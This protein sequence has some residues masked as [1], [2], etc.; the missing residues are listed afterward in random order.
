MKRGGVEVNADRVRSWEF[1]FR[2][3]VFGEVFIKEMRH[4]FDVLVASRVKLDNFC[5]EGGQ[6]PKTWKQVEEMV[7]SPQFFETFIEGGKTGELV[8]YIFKWIYAATMETADWGW[9]EDALSAYFAREGMHVS[10]GPSSG[11][12][13][14]VHLIKRYAKKV[15]TNSALTAFKEKQI[16]SWGFSIELHKKLLE[17][18]SFP[19]ANYAWEAHDIS[20]MLDELTKRKMT[21]VGVCVF[22]TLHTLP[23]NPA[24]LVK[25]RVNAAIQTAL[26]NGVDEV[27]FRAYV[28]QC[29][30]ESLFGGG[31]EAGRVLKM[32]HQRK[33]EEEDLVGSRDGEDPMDSDDWDILRRAAEGNGVENEA[34]GQL[35]DCLFVPDIN[36]TTASQIDE[37]IAEK[38]AEKDETE[39]KIDDV[40]GCETVR[41]NC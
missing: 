12:R 16:K 24:Y 2:T 14:R 17:D 29:V 34:A 10:L 3:Q 22:L 40:F 35:V 21:R 15:A 5:G 30:R 9:I 33:E 18:G 28:D 36:A 7:L 20:D 26:A 25:C 8:G 38:I 23:S 13:C 37:K 4:V 1:F 39:Q 27:E 31:L 19:D 6:H 11:D 41:T 32:V